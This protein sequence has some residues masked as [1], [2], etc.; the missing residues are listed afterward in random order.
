M[1]TS[2][3]ATGGWPIRLTASG[4]LMLLPHGCWGQRRPRV[5]R[6][7]H[8]SLALCSSH[9]RFT[10]MR[11][12]RCICGAVAQAV[13][14]RLRRDLKPCRLARGLRLRSP[15]VRQGVHEQEAPTA[16]VTR[17]GLNSARQRCVRVRDLDT[18]PFIGPCHRD[19]ARS[20][21]VQDS[22]GDHLAGQQLNGLQRL[23]RQGEAQISGQRDNSATCCRYSVDSS[24]DRES[25]RRTFGTAT[26]HDDNLTLVVASVKEAF[27]PTSA[28]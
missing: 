8:G 23:V 4:S 11:G 26:R 3:Q 5:G 14:R 7:R 21:R 28:V 22:I 25:V 27:H 13:G 12:E 10:R 24:R 2:D 1:A 16:F 20:I 6:R 17:A 15:V 9:G 19:S 18:K